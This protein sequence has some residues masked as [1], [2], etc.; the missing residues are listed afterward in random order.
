MKQNKKSQA[1]ILYIVVFILIAG[2]LILVTDKIGEKFT[3]KIVAMN[4]SSTFISSSTTAQI[5]SFRA[6]SIYLDYIFFGVFIAV[7]LGA[8]VMAYFSDNY[9]I[10]FVAFFLILV[11]SIVMG[12]VFKDIYN[13]IE[14]ILRTAN[15]YKYM[16]FIFNMLPKIVFVVGIVV[17]VLMF[18][19]PKKMGMY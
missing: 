2:L 18:V 9:A 3:D 11:I 10:F 4:D 14:P 7:A 6:K 15:T 12:V 5:Q 17:G 1:M 8:M 16:P 13:S 19:K